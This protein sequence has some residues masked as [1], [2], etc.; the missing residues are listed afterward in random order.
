M[1]LF[2]GFEE[3]AAELDK[4]ARAKHRRHEQAVGRERAP[5]LDQRAGKIVDAMQREPRDDEI[6]ARLLEG[7]IS[8]SQT[9][10]GR[11]QSAASSGTLSA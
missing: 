10:E 4:R 11:G 7:Q 8:S 9:S 5:H 6:E 2:L 1:R 3:S